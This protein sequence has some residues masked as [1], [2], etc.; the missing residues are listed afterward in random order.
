LSY[1]S[2]LRVEFALPAILTLALGIGL[3]T[4]VFTVVNAL[5][6]PRLPVHDQPRNPL[7]GDP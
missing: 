3:S 1:R 2:L 4:A 6:L 5:L 7:G